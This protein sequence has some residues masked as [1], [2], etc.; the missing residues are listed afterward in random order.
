MPLL[1]HV[2]ARWADLEEVGRSR[3]AEVYYGEHR[4]FCRLL[5]RYSAFADVRDGIV[6]LRLVLN[7]F[8]KPWVTLALAKYI[9]VDPYWVDV[10]AN[11]GYYTLLMAAACSPEG[12]V[13]ACEPNRLLAEKYLLQNLALNGCREQAE[14]RQKVIGGRDRKRVDFVRA[15]RRPGSVIPGTLGAFT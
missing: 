14:I 7:G 9:Q 11:C 2:L 12:R 1:P 3:A 8:W 10:G 5:G 6:G 13:V 15:P 4:V